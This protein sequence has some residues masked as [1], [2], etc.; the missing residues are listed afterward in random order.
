MK[1]AS[2]MGKKKGKAAPAAKPEQSEPALKSIAFYSEICETKSGNWIQ[3]PIVGI[4]NAARD[5]CIRYEIELGLSPQARTKIKIDRN[6][7]KTLRDRML[8]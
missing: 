8:S 7:N 2:V 5:A 4:A 3:N 6:A 1:K